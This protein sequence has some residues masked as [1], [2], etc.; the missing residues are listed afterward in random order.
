MSNPKWN[1]DLPV[2][3]YGKRGVQVPL[4]QAIQNPSSV[5]N[6]TP[7]TYLPLPANQLPKQK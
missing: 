5:I 6:T 7:K 3:K 2:T 1:S 4:D